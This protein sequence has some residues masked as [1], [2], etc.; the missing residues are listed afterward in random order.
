[1]TMDDE[2][3]L[4]PALKEC[5][6][7]KRDLDVSMFGPNRRSPD[8]WRPQCKPC[9]SA[10]SRRQRAA[11]PERRRA[12]CRGWVARNLEKQRASERKWA[13]A[14]RE[15][16]RLRALARYAANPQRQAEKTKQWVATHPETARA[17]AHRAS[18]NRRARERQA[19]IENVDPRVVFDRDAGICGICRLPVNPTER[20]HVDH[21]IPLSKGGLHAYANVQLSHARCNISKGARLV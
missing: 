15:Q 21:V 11:N 9:V 6:G 7:C 16:E 19:F 20:W 10:A 17:I 1:M 3:I 13:A 2:D 4:M 8:G 18:C 12:Y 14:N 5:T